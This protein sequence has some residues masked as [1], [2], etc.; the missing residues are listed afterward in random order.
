[1]QSLHLIYKNLNL[2]FFAVVLSLL[3]TMV[4]LP[5]SSLGFDKRL[6]TGILAGWSGTYYDERD[7]YPSIHDG[8]VLGGHVE[9]G[10]NRVFALA[11]D[12]SVDL[13][14]PYDLFEWGII[15]DEDGKEML[16]WAKPKRVTNYF[17]TSGAFS[18]LYA[19]DLFKV[20]PVFAVGVI[21][22]R[23]DR[24]IDEERET[25]RAFGIRIGGGFEYYLQ[26]FSFGAGIYSDRFLV[27][28]A[29]VI[30]RTFLALKGAVVFDLG[31]KSLE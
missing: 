22:V 1:M 18:I 20:V 23:V 26:R 21:V 4:A 30:H 7:V 12:G 2:N 8:V 6:Q 3:G 9:Y 5:S 16:G 19:I 17:H 25:K 24:R 29:E 13:H 27:G 14:L 28:N 31:A 11:V 10:L 15:K